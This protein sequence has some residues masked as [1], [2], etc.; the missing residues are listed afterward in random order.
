MKQLMID[1]IQF[2]LLVVAQVLVSSFVN[3]GPSVMICFY[4]FY[5]LSSSSRTSPARLLISAFLLGFFVDFYSNGVLGLHASASVLLAFIQPLLMKIILRGSDI[6]KQARPG[7]ANSGATRFTIYIFSGLLFHHIF[8]AI[9]ENFGT[10]FMSESIA[11]ILI[12][13]L[14]NTLI[15]VLIEFGIFYKK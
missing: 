14:L 5:I 10:P 11:R 1:I 2:L 7:L 15:I 4:P 9:V 12:S 13:V 6:E 8:L 3:F